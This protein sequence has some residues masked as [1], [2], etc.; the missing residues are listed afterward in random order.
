MPKNAEGIG[1]RATWQKRALANALAQSDTFRSAQQIHA[2]LREGGDRIGLTTVYNQL[3][4]MAGSGLVDVLR[5][6]D[7]ETLYRRCSTEEHHHHLLCRSCGKTVEIDAP[8]IE[9]WA[10]NIARSRRFSDAVHTLEIVGTCQACRRAAK[11]NA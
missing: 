8:E 9:Q 1:E 3:R 10:T 7:G 11:A 5:A 6:E 4:A 2:Q